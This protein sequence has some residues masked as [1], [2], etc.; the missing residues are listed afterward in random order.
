MR[1]HPLGCLN[2]LQNKKNSETFLRSK[3]Y[4]K[5]HD[6]N[7]LSLTECSYALGLQ[8]YLAAIVS[9]GFLGFCF[10]RFV[11]VVCTCFVL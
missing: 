4:T 1:D 7:R 9:F 11:F 3:G 8:A 2:D 5:I 6:T 10:I